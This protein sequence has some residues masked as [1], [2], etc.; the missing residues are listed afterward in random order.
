MRVYLDMSKVRE[1]D[2]ANQDMDSKLLRFK[3]L[4]FCFNCFSKAHTT[5]RCSETKRGFGQPTTDNNGQENESVKTFN[6]LDL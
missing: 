2:K 5:N 3:P 4:G 6:S 1:P